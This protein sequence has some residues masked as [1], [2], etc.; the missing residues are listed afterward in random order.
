MSNTLQDT[1]EVQSAKAEKQPLCNG[2]YLV[3]K[4]AYS[5]L[6]DAI[7]NG[8]AHRVSDSTNLSAD[9]QPDAVVLVDMMLMMQKSLSVLGQD[10]NWDLFWFDDGRHYDT[11]EVD[12]V[13]CSEND[14][15]Q[16][17][18]H[19][20]YVYDS[21]KNES[22]LHALKCGQADYKNESA[23]MSIGEESGLMAVL[24]A[25]V[26]LDDDLDIIGD[27]H[28]VA[29]YDGEREYRIRDLALM[30]QSMSNGK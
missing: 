20:L 5:S 6:E 13:F 28:S 30:K 8:G 15:E 10:K 2:L 25:M 7:E 19:G 16:P 27:S 22:L 11:S 18:K 14:A 9:S 29:W 21:A 24:H 26:D 1:Q 23:N 17:F 4:S 12:S 3:N